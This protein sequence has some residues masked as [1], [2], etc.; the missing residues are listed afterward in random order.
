MRIVKCSY[1]VEAQAEPP[2][3]ISV[4]ADQDTKPLE[5]ADNVFGHNTLACQLPVRSLLLIRQ[6]VVLAFLVRCATVA[7]MFVDALVATIT[8]AASFL[9]QRQ[10]TCLKQGE[11][12]RFALAKGGCQQT[13]RAG[14]HYELSLAGVALLLAA[15]VL[16]LFF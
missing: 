13:A 8:G 9:L 4:R 11:I 1:E 5:P 2:P 14:L 12:V 3:A 10:P 6:W 7:M 15:V 16:F